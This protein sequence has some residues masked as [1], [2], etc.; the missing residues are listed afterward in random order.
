MFIS[1][2]HDSPE[3]VSI[4]DDTNNKLSGIACL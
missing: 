3:G 4:K 1:S 2:D